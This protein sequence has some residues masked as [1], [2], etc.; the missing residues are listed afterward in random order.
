MYIAKFN[1]IMPLDKDKDKVQGITSIISWTATNKL[2][3]DASVTIFVVPVNYSYFISS[4]VL[5]KQNAP[6]PT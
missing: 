3:V 2:V 6:V 1:S 4:I 5:W